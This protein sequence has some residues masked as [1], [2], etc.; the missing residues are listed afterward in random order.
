[1]FRARFVQPSRPQPGRR[2]SALAVFGVVALL[3]GLLGGC[4]STTDDETGPDGNGE[5]GSAD[6]L[7]IDPGF[8]LPVEH[9]PIVPSPAAAGGEGAEG[10]GADVAPTLPPTPR[11]PHAEACLELGTAWSQAN[12]ALV[13]LS[14][15]HPRQLVN[16]FRVASVEMSRA[17]PMPG[18][19]GPWLIFANYL[20]LVNQGF[21]DV[22]RDNIEDV[23]AAL[24]QS[25]TAADTEAAAA[26]GEAITAFVSG[27]CIG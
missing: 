8:T 26:A 18:I 2:H 17:V 9:D 24:S 20:F 13:N 12:Q 5:T 6:G 27:G 14:A 25:V 22:D 15:D 16:S 23:A 10:S 7:V 4:G 21:E 11:D 19:A 3:A 1:V